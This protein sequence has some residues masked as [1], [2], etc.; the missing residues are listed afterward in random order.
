MELREMRSF[1]AAARLRSISRAGN[2]LG[3]GQP[4]VTNHIK[5]LEEELGTPLFDRIKRPIQLTPVGSVFYQR[6]ASLVE[7]IDQIVSSVSKAEDEGPVRLA[8]T[9]GII[10]HTLLGSVDSFLSRY[11]NV[12]LRIQSRA[13]R[14]VLQMV[15]E[16]EVDFGIVPGLQRD[17]GFNFQAL[18]PYERVLLVPINHPLL[19][20]NPISLD[21]IAQWPLILMGR[22]TATRTLLEEQFQRRGLS[23]ETVM[24][25]D[26]MDMV[27][28]YVATGLGIAIGPRLAVDQG[29]EYKL[30][31]I[32]LSTI[33]PVEQTGI[34]TLRGKSLSRPVQ[35]FIS[36]LQENLGAVGSSPNQ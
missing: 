16:G 8:S 28:R 10:S 21:Q 23:Y 32:N 15:K 31:I 4:S 25:L 17:E 24:E 11:P 36:V 22:G 13:K 12:H 33:L 27:K 6:V 7:E 14:E 1:C 9:N 20:V 30:G 3:I 26:G 2:Y 35:N 34:L 5:R 29:D 18:F 19:E